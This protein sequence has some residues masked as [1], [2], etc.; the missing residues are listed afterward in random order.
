MALVLLT[1][2]GFGVVAFCLF[3]AK[4]FAHWLYRLLYR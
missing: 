3:T 4:D 2:F 1:A